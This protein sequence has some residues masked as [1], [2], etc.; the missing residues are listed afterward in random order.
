MDDLGNLIG[1]AGVWHI[2]V[3]LIALWALEMR[4][5]VRAARKRRRPRHRSAR[6][7]VHPRR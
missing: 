5:S 2:V 4:A 3:V 7:P 1:Q 6:A